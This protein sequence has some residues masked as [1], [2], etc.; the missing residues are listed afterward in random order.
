MPSRIVRLTP[1]RNDPLTL[2]T[3]RLHRIFEI[4]K[5][6]VSTKH[7]K[8]RDVKLY[9]HCPEAETDHLYSRR[10]Y[11]HALHRPNT[12]CCA[13]AFAFL[14]KTYQA[15]ILLHEF[16]HIATRDGELEADRWVMVKM[17]IPLLYRGSQKL[18]WVDVQTINRMIA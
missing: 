5:D 3:N 15:G 4:V 18:E 7:R 9:V 17:G 2:K 16:G 1:R 8:L 6:F 11:C 14:P 12:I 10:Q 13:G